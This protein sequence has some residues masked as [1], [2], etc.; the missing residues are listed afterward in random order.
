MESLENKVARYGKSLIINFSIL[1]RAAGI[2]DPT[3]ETIQHM[4]Q[5]LLDDMEVFLEETGDFTIK[6]IEGSFYVEGI[7][8]KGGLSD[9]EVLTSFAR[10]FKKKMIGMFDFRAPLTVDDLVQFAYALKEGFEAAE[11][12]SILEQKL[13]NRIAIGGPV[14]LQREEG[15]DLKD[16]YAVAKRSYVKALSSLREMNESI[17][18]GMRVKLKRI[19]RAI[20]LMVDSILND[21]SYLLGLT[22]MR[23]FE[24][25]SHFHPVNVSIL[26]ML[27]HLLGTL[28]AIVAASSTPRATF[29]RKN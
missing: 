23:N 12:Q 5:K 24:D 3:N 1:V 13:T 17:K 14:F 2:Y 15:V 6:I 10:E 16:N 4:A 18:A 20:Q 29:T 28:G 26:S 7:R 27:F 9:I 11:V 8:I 25:Y 21:E 22:R 19:K